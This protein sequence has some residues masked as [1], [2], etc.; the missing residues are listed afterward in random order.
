[1]CQN[2]RNVAHSECRQRSDLAWIF[3]RMYARTYRVLLSLENTR[4]QIY[5][6]V[7][8]FLCAPSSR[9]QYLHDPTLLPTDYFISLSQSRHHSPTKR[10]QGGIPL[11]LQ[12]G[13]KIPKVG[14]PT[15]NFGT[16]FHISLSEALQTLQKYTQNLPLL[17]IKLNF[18]VD[19]HNLTSIKYTLLQTKMT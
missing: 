19:L 13:N 11:A 7:L 17:F 9:P 8:T 15:L 5:C 12:S 3:V 2:I 6:A 4:S 1:M 14:T 10:A 18:L 16:H